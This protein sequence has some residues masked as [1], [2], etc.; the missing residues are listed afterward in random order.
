MT[1]GSICMISA[2]SP[3]IFAGW[4]DVVT[5]AACTAA[6][7]GEVSGVRAMDIDRERWIW[8]IRRQTTI[9]PGGLIDKPT[10]GRHARQV[11]II[12]EVQ[13]LL[14]KRLD[15]AESPD[16]RLS[17]GPAADASAPQ[18]CVTRRAGTT[19]SRSWDTSTCAVMTCG[20]PA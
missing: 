8:T 18:C 10:K 3:G 15:S 14:A 13:P 1:Y 5:F 6:R 7:I 20:I 19:S 11:P 2:R 4:G 9:G 12:R 16:E 17:P